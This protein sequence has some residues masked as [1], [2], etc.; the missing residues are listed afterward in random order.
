MQSCGWWSHESQLVGWHWQAWNAPPLLWCH[1]IC[2]AWWLLQ[3]KCCPQVREKKKTSHTLNS[4]WLASAMTESERRSSL[5]SITTDCRQ[6]SC[7]FRLPAAGTLFC[8]CFCP[9]PLQTPVKDI[10]Q[11]GVVMPSRCWEEDLGRQLTPD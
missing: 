1:C 9:Y 6:A 10:T 3:K 11:S 8:F 5:Q 7:A 2:H 4:Q